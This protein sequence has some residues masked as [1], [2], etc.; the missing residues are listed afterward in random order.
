MDSPEEVSFIVLS[1]IQYLERLNAWGD[2][3]F[4]KHFSP[5]FVYLLYYNDLDR[6]IIIVIIFF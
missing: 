6:Y 1:L 5:F 3:V 2:K 4:L